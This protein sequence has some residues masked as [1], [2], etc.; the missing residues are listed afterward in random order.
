MPFKRRM[1]EARPK[2]RTPPKPKEPGRQDVRLQPGDV[3]LFPYGDGRGKV[4]TGI[5]V[6][7]S[8]SNRHD[9]CDVVDETGRV[10][11]IHKILKDP[12]FPSAGAFY[13]EPDI[14]VGHDEEWM[15]FEISVEGSR[16]RFSE[17]HRIAGREK[18]RDVHMAM[19]EKKAAEAK[20]KAERVIDC[21]GCS[22]DREAGCRIGEQRE[23][24]THRRSF[25]EG[26][27]N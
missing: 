6:R 8:S 11:H 27:N 17:A 14:L 9:N 25:K 20:A 21:Q 23:T 18:R 4:V 13:D 1:G 7:I 16:K 2:H 22:H 3:I 19:E 26:G 12:L 5:V 15:R 24:C 10:H